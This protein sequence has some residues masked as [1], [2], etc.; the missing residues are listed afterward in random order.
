MTW[1]TKPSAI[2]PEIPY[3]QSENGIIGHTF[4]YGLGLMLAAYDG[5]EYIQHGGYFPPYHTLMSLFPTQNLGIFTS[6]NEGLAYVD[7]SVLHAFIFELLRGSSNAKEIALQQWSKLKAIKEEKKS[8]EEKV[9]ETFLN[10]KKNS[11]PVYAEDD[12]VGKYGS[13]GSGTILNLRLFLLC[14]HLY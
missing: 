11:S 3:K 9:L 5:F 1:M 2:M 10:E 6:T 8:K 14:L 7:A 12:I 4:G 13:G